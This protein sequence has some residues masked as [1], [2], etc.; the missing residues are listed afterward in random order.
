[1]Q[2]GTITKKVV[3]CGTSFCGVI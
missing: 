1:M 2:L 3:S